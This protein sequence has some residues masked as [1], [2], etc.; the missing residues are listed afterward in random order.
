MCRD[1]HASVR[2]SATRSLAGK[3]GVKPETVKG[4][5][6]SGKISFTQIDRSADHTYTPSGFLFLSKPPGY[7]VSL[8]YWIAAMTC[9]CFMQP[10]MI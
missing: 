9:K 2:V 5:E 7:Q 6:S 8:D 3:V 10:F 1:G 4:C